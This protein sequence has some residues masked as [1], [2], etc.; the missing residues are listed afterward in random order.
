MAP[1]KSFLLL[2]IAIFA[3]LAIAQ[4]QNGVWMCSQASSTTQGSLEYVDCCENT[5]DRKINDVTSLTCMVQGTDGA[6]APWNNQGNN[7]CGQQPTECVFSDDKAN[8]C[9][10]GE[11]ACFSKENSTVVDCCAGLCDVTIG[12]EE[13]NNLNV[14]CVL[15]TKPIDNYF[16][17]DKTTIIEQKIVCPKCQAEPKYE[18][19]CQDANDKVTDCCKG[20]CKSVITAND[21]QCYDATSQQWVANEKCPQ[22]QSTQCDRTIDTIPA[23]QC[24]PELLCKKPIDGAIQY[25]D[26]NCENFPCGTETTVQCVTP[27]VFN[28][29]SYNYIVTPQACTTT[30]TS[31][32]NTLVHDGSYTCPDCNPPTT[33]QWLCTHEIEGKQVLGPCDCDKYTQYQ[34][35]LTQRVYNETK[36]DNIVFPCRDTTS[37][38]TLQPIC[39]RITTTGTYISTDETICGSKP[40]AKTCP[41]PT[42][43]QE[44]EYLCTAT[45]FG[46]VLTAPC[47]DLCKILREKG[48]DVYCQDHQFKPVCVKRGTYT[49]VPTTFCEDTIPNAPTFESCQ[50]DTSKCRHHW[51]C[52]VTVDTFTYSGPCVTFNAELC[53]K[54]RGDDKLRCLDGVIQTKCVNSYTFVATTNTALCPP[55]TAPFPATATTTS[56][57]VSNICPLPEDCKDAKY[58]WECMSSQVNADGTVTNTT[59]PMVS[60]SATTAAQQGSTNT[61]ECGPTCE[62]YKLYSRCKRLADGV[63]VPEWNCDPLT[64]PLAYTGSVWCPANLPK[65]KCG[66]DCALICS[67]DV[68]GS[69]YYFPCE[70]YEQ[71]CYRFSQS[72]C[73]DIKIKSDCGTLSADNVFIPSQDQE[74]CK[75]L[76]SPWGQQWLPTSVPQYDCKQDTTV[77]SMELLSTSSMNQLSQIHELAIMNNANPCK[78]EWLCERVNADGVTELGPC[79]CDWLQTDKCTSVSRVT[80]KCYEFSAANP[81]PTLVTDDSKCAPYPQPFVECPIQEGCQDNYEWLCT[82]SSSSSGTLFPCSS[83]CDSFLISNQHC[84]NFTIVADCYE[85]TNSPPVLSSQFYCHTSVG[86]AFPP[87]YNPFMTCPGSQRFCDPV[88][89]NKYNWQC[90]LNGNKFYPVPCT[91]DLGADWYQKFGCEFKLLAVCVD[92]YGAFV[93]DSMCTSS[94]PSI[95]SPFTPSTVEV[96]NKC[97]EE[98]VELQCYRNGD[99]T[100]PVDCKADCKLRGDCDS[101]FVQAICHIT[102]N[103][104]AV[105]P[106]SSCSAFTAL[107]INN[108]FDYTGIKYC[109]SQKYDKYCHIKYICRA[110]STT[111]NS[112]IEFDCGKGDVCGYLPPFENK[113]QQFKVE[114]ICVNYDPSQ[115]SNPA[116]WTPVATNACDAAGLFAPFSRVCPEFLP[117]ECYSQVTY[118]WLCVDSPSNTQGITFDDEP[119]V[120]K[121]PTCKD[122]RHLYDS[123]CQDYAISANCYQ[124]VTTPGQP[125]TYTQV[126]SSYCAWT[127]WP[128]MLDNSPVSLFCRCEK[129]K[130][131]AINWPRCNIFTFDEVI[132]TPGTITW[133][134]NPTSDPCV[135]GEVMVTYTSDDFI[136]ASIGGD[137]VPVSQG[138]I[139]LTTGKGIS[140]RTLKDPTKQR[141]NVATTIISPCGNTTSPSTPVDTFCARTK[142]AEPFICDNDAQACICPP[143]TWGE[144]CE[145]GCENGMTWDEKLQSCVCPPRTIFD[146]STKKC[147]KKCTHKTNPNGDCMNE[148][149]WSPRTCTCQC[150]DGFYGDKCECFERYFNVTFKQ[151][152]QDFEKYQAM[153]KELIAKYI[154]YDMQL[155][156]DLLSVV[157]TT[158]TEQGFVVT[159]RLRSCD[160]KLIELFT[161]LFEEW[162]KRYNASQTMVVQQDNTNNQQDDVSAVNN[163]DVAQSAGGVTFVSGIYVN[164]PEPKPNNIATISTMIAMVVVA[165]VAML[166]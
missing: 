72:F 41:C 64:N 12:E 160:E 46:T 49:I 86:T 17:V 164:N 156:D 67:I 130:N 140:S 69:Q 42:T 79:E 90:Y 75:K 147:V 100:L 107:Q 59:R 10:E 93:P 35:Y 40:E 22:F 23:D 118:D 135:D 18:W 157:L 146:P 71:Y 11:W 87:S 149:V 161:K 8:K 77:A 57:A 21:V 13:V 58:A 65:E 28:P 92:Q 50:I 155:A 82:D 61:C 103:P 31:S 112:Y 97:K 139:D 88:E 152:P 151:E 16:C 162:F 95:P 102:G 148:G 105:L 142:C 1:T 4:A 15:E 137:R 6:L 91:C 30:T 55:L 14:Q 60:A 131:R 37:E 114:P 113:C 121:R 133:N 128:I 62:G 56:F 63:Y 47:P 136:Y 9:L 89:Q 2:I 166:M 109:K 19:Q 94:T 138:S 26:C 158:K 163:S 48:A 145:L 123:P 117:K 153:W 54:L 5:C 24:K 134:N 25:V 154:A 81:T 34:W 108:G 27:T 119:W 20:T 99:L 104:S 126:A 32:P 36:K 116:Y 159:F 124:I 143:G 29:S 150:K 125:T 96:C 85:T 83:A 45:V 141:I 120:C 129:C 3:L 115:P 122:R 38:F 52:S 76:S 73:G 51:E 74:C 84:K 39:V 68:N 111:T 110:W 53:R 98:R 106:L 66:S 7:P 144:K 78:Y 165:I 70:Y 80:G 44:Y 127:Q 43:E 132:L 33:G 101:Y